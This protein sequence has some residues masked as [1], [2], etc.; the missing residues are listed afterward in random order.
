[1]GW[2]SR[3][4][5]QLRIAGHGDVEITRK[6]SDY[7]ILH[8]TKSNIP[9]LLWKGKDKNNLREQLKIWYGVE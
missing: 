1:M 8:I 9:I 5:K 2:M 7:H 3:L 6:G 4:E